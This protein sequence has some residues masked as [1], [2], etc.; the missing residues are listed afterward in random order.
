MD[1]SETETAYFALLRAREEAQELRS[2]LEYL[3]TETQRLRR[4]SSEAAALVD[5]VDRRY[6]RVLQPSDQT[7]T[8]TIT[9]RLA[10]IHDELQRLPD[11]IDAADEFVHVCEEQYHALKDAPDVS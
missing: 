10:L 3:H 6:R 1:S 2:Y 11:R 8:E 4:S 5:T 9:A 7:L